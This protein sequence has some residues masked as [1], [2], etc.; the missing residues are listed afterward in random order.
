MPS[1]ETP[2]TTRFSAAFKGLHWAAV[3]FV[4][5]LLY[6]GFTLS[7]E[8]ATWHFGFGILLLVVMVIWLAYKAGKPR[9][10]FPADMPRWQQIAARAVHHSLYLFVT[11]QPIFGL[12]LVTTSKGSP[13]AFGFIPLKIA[14][15]D[16]I[17]GIGEVLHVGNAYLIATLLALHFIGALYH[18]FIR[19]DDVLKRILPG[20]A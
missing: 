13:M 5:I 11:L 17:H 7:R 2:T 19:R 12:M 9:P 18:H 15:H 6:T 8:N 14:R 20:G 1:P 10:P 4:L 16:A 3:T